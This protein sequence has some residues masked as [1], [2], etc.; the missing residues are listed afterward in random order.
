MASH[1][2]WALGEPCL[3]VRHFDC[4]NQMSQCSKAMQGSQ[5]RYAAWLDH[6]W[7]HTHNQQFD[8]LCELTFT[9]A[10]SVVSY[11]GGFTAGV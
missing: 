11:S 9:K 1:H 6:T 8:G 2:Q 7:L 3:A 5:L 10:P 4:C